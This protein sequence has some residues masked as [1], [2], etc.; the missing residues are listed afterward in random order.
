MANLGSVSVA[1]QTAA[2][3]SNTG[4]ISQRARR[5]ASW[6]YWI[7]GLSVVNSVIVLSGSTAHFLVG[8]GVTE[9]FDVAGQQTGGAGKM[10]ALVISLLCAGMF[11]VFG[12]FASKPQTWAFFLG[13]GLYGLDALLLVAFKDYFSVAFHCWALYRLYLGLA[14]ARIYVPAQAANTPLG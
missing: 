8:L 12:Y 3:K 2:L 14:A 10:T 5:G 7:A 9:A 6:F 11:G 13:M 4:V 1:A